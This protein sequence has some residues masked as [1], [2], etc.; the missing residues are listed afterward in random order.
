MKCPFCEHPDSYVVDSRANEEHKII[1]RRRV[2]EACNKRFTT[3]EK[4]QF[5]ELTVIKRS[6]VKKLFER[7]KIEKAI[8]TALHKRNITDKQINELVSRIVLEIENS[9]LR[10]ISTRKIGDIIMKELAEIDQVAYIRFAS[11]YKDFSTAHDFSV[12]AGK[13]KK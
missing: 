3:F 5:R 11:V 10:E 4:I 6:G 8:T 2:C 13:L 12:F 7:Q 9:N 1:R